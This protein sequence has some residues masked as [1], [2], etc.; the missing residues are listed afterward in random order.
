M[1]EL[2][3]DEYELFKELLRE[4]EINQCDHEPKGDIECY[5]CGEKGDHMF[6]CVKCK[7]IITTDCPAHTDPHREDFPYCPRCV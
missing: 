6:D 1:V 5:C 2:S 7:S 3:D 4:R